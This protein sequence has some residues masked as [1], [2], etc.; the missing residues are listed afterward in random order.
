MN[1]ALYQFCQRKFKTKLSGSLKLSSLAKQLHSQYAFGRIN[2][3]NLQFDSTDR[4]AL[5]DHVYQENKLHLF[6]DYYEQPQSRV[7]NAGEFRNEKVN[8]HAVSEGFILVN[9]LDS[10][11]VNKQNISLSP[12]T[13]LGVYLKESEITSVQH[14][15]IVL[16]ENLS[17]MSALSQLILP[18]N[19]DN[20]LFLYRG[21]IKAA[22]RTNHAYHFF[23]RF[24][25]SKNL[26][27]FSDLDPA[28]I[29]ISLSSGAHFW[30][31]PED[32]SAINISLTGYE[33]EWFTQVASV[34]WLNKQESMPKPCQTAFVEM[35]LS[36]KTLKQEQ[37]LALNM[38]LSLYQL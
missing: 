30:L 5:V 22:Q 34:K 38:Q 36:H 28:G 6:R 17:I 10:I 3:E 15:I 31:A 11:Q 4:Q 9:A 32:F 25:E 26:V 37:M 8:S 14:D 19:L 24:R 35:C 23:R 33:Q 12:L 13:S 21:D 7:E 1:K 2:G 16:V 27:C 18:I 20:A 29:Q